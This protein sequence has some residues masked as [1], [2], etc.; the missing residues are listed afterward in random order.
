[1]YE[2]YTYSLSTCSPLKCGQRAKYHFFFSEMGFLTIS[3]ERFL[4]KV[5]KLSTKSLKIK[6]LE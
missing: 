5:N 1:M 2:L 3:N 4:F 6:I